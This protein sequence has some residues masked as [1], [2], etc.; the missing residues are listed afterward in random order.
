[1]TSLLLHLPVALVYALSGGRLLKNTHRKLKNMRRSDAYNWASDNGL[2]TEDLN[3]L[4]RDRIKYDLSLVLGGLGLGLIIT[5]FAIFL[6][7]L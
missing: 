6:G 7:V 5:T 1:M 4:E 3:F 2:D